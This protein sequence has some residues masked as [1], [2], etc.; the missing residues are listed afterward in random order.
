MAQ[1]DRVERRRST[2]R[3]HLLIAAMLV[4]SILVGSLLAGQSAVGTEHPPRTSAGPA[5]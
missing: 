3:D 4:L 2:A 5:G 1:S